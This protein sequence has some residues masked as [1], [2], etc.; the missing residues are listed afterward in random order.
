VVV[1]E[2]FAA[3]AWPGEDPIGKAIRLY[4]C[5]FTVGGVARDVRSRGVD[6]PALG[7]SLDE[8]S[9]AVMYVPY[10]DIGPF[11][12]RSGGDPEQLVE[13]IRTI[14]ASL[15]PRWQLSFTTLERRVEDS[16]ARP[17]FYAVATGLFA[18]TTLLMALVGLYGLVAHEVGRRVPEIGLRKAL[19]APDHRVRAMILREALSPVG[20]GVAVGL[21]ITFALAGALERLLYGMEAL[22]PWVVGVVVATIGVVSV[23]ACAV[24]ATRAVTVD[25]ARSLNGL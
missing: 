7:S 12:V 20:W 9:T 25:P 5:C 6:A 2:T 23:A 18:A 13:P 11:L 4:D 24:P 1:S 17:R 10:T 21:V 19:G 22:D 16:L 8:A 14:V 3:L 15:Q